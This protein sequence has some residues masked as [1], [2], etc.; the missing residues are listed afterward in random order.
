MSNLESVWTAKRVRQLATLWSEGLSASQIAAELHCGLTRNAVIG[1]VHRIGLPERKA[2]ALAPT[3]P[4]VLEER[5]HRKR[6]RERLYR[7]RWIIARREFK[8]EAWSPQA[9]VFAAPR[10]RTLLELGPHDCRW[11]LGDPRNPAF[12]FCGALVTVKGCPYC[13]A[14]ARLA[15][16]PSKP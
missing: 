2:R 1:K 11:G 3:N 13:V 4:A 7:K 15:Y 9:V 5:R 8:S 14:H 16:L 6:E 12:L 10:P